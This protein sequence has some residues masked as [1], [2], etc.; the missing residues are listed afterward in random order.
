VSCRSCQGHN[1]S[2]EVV[3]V[4]DGSG[5]TSETSESLD[6][7]SPPLPDVGVAAAAEA[8][9]EVEVELRVTNKRKRG[10]YRGQLHNPDVPVAAAGGVPLAF[11]FMVVQAPI[12]QIYR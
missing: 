12:R 2:D 4:G 6:A 11:T 10:K 9:G 5:K 8:T 7:G 3:D 1:S